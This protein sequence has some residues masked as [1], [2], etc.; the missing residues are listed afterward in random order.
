MSLEDGDSK[1]RRR[2]W[3]EVLRDIIKK[4]KATEKETKK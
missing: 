1:K 3:R 4:R 2:R